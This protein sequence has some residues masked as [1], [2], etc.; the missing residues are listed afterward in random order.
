MQRH[1]MTLC[2]QRSDSMC[3]IIVLWDNRLT[4][5]GRRKGEQKV[6][7]KIIKMMLRPAVFF[8]QA[9]WEFLRAIFPRRFVALYI[10]RD[11]SNRL[12]V[13]ESSHGDC[14]IIHLNIGGTLYDT[15]IAT[16]CREEV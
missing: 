3:M 15:T 11:C 4:V 13:M 2:Q 14:E 5:S 10:R 16:L 12:V 6:A 9:Y 1:R 7:W 8:F